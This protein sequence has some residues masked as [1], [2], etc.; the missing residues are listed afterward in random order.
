[1]EDADVIGKNGNIIWRKA[2]MAVAVTG[3]LG[4]A[5]T[6]PALAGISPISLGAP[7]PTQEL[8]KLRGG[9]DVGGM[10]VKLGV[11]MA[12]AV[13]GVLTSQTTLT[14][15]LGNTLTVNGA[16]AL[17]QVVQVGDNNHVAQ[18]TLRNL[19]VL[20]TL[21]QNTMNNAV[22]QHLT[23]VDMTVTGWHAVQQAV[24]TG[25]ILTQSAVVRNMR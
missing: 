2:A 25:Q 8:A 3:I 23:A 19:P 1:M 10:V 22:I 7:V 14:S 21:I 11:Q 20:T 9:F 15:G 6:T 13:N 5:G 24:A 12:T 4:V 16:G 18:S 17:R